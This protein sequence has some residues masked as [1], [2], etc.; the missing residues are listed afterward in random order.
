MSYESKTIDKIIDDI[1]FNKAFLPAIQRKFVWPSWK[2][3]KLFDSIMRNFPIGSFLFW[4]LKAEKAGEYVFY[5]FL[6]SYHERYPYNELKKGAFRHSEII[7]VLDGQQ[8]LSSIFIGLMGTHAQKIKHFK[9]KS[10]YA[11]P[12]TKL[13]LNLLSLPYEIEKKNED[14]DIIK[15]VSDKTFEF[16]FLTPEQAEITEEKKEDGT[17]KYNCWF[18]TGKVL[19]WSDSPDIDT[20]YDKLIEDKEEAYIEALK[21]QRQFIKNGLRT[22]HKRIKSD[23]L[24]NYFKVSSDDLEEILEIF[25][26]VNSGGTILSKTDLLFSTIVANWSDGREQIENFLKFIN[27]KGNNSFSFS[28]DFLMRSCLVLSDLPVLF[29]VNSF[30]SENVVLIK[31]NWENI[32]KSIAKAVDLLVDFGFCKENLTSQNVIIIIAYHLFKGGNDNNLSKENIRKYLLHALLMKI[33]GGQG[34]Q[35]IATLRNGLLT[36]ESIKNKTFI[37]RSKE[38]PFAHL[39]ELKLPAN[40][41][42]KIDNEDLQDFMNYKKGADSFFVLSLLYP[43]LKYSEKSFHQ[44]HIHPT[45][46]FNLTN[47]K[48]RGISE[49]KCNLWSN[50]KDTVPNL[51]IM[52]GTQNSAKNGTPFEVWLDNKF[53][54][55]MFSKV[56]YLA[57]NFIPQNISY[58]LEDFETFYER[59]KK[60]LIETLRKNI[61]GL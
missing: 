18:L 49:E 53:S 29:K 46:Q 17:K 45:T 35:V 19:K 15:V 14:N 52:E 61:A 12:E 13:Y 50:L 11:Y 42:L 30:K 9:S 26:R 59:R 37:L 55:E 41:T 6:K 31:N 54:D 5:E 33:Y 60:I 22:L 51:Q 39:L 24:I 23:R 56:S 38:F 36:E 7:G 47:L 21:S 20:I 40:K 58:K 57:S 8:R 16:R 32:K 2:I 25:I 48:D 34:D 44:D 3:E 1:E 4:E 43:S 10:E 27:E 28:N